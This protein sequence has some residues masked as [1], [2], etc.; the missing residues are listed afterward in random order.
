MIIAAY[1]IFGFTLLQLLIVTVNLI[2]KEKINHLES[3]FNGLVS[4]LI[5]V[6]NE[7]LN[8]GNLLSDLQKQ[9]YPNIEIIVFDDQS[10]DNTSEIVKQFMESDN[11]IKLIRSMELPSGWLGKNYACHEMSKHAKGNYLLFLDADVSL[12]RRIIFLQYIIYPHRQH[13]SSHRVSIT[14]LISS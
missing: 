12:K 10:T 2:F 1:F 6:R 5:P 8:I 7:E 11:R 9:D 13:G 4:V 14:L 3:D